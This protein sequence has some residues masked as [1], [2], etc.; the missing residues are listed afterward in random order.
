[1]RNINNPHLESIEKILKANAE[2]YA[3]I[4]PNGNLVD[5]REKPLAQP[6]SENSILGVTKPKQIIWQ[7]GVQ[8]DEVSIHDKGY[9]MNL[10]DEDGYEYEG[11]G[12]YSCG[13]LVD[14]E[15]HEKS[16]EPLP[17]ELRNIQLI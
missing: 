12:Y 15:I 1:M 7:Q 2:G 3:G 9:V 5:R 6:V 11:I 13:E 14:I 16:K 4:M 10:E 17:I 8:V